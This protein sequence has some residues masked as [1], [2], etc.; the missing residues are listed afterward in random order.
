MSW[1]GLANRLKSPISAK[2]VMAEIWATPRNA[3]MAAATLVSDHDG[4]NSCICLASRSAARLRFLDG[5]QEFF[6]GDL[7][8]RMLGS[9]RREPKPIFARPMPAVGINA[10]VPQ[11]ETQH[12]LLRASQRRHRR[13]PGVTK[14]AHRLMSVVRDP[15]WRQL[16]RTEQRGLRNGVAAVGFHPI[17]RPRRN[18]RG[19]DHLA[20]MAKR[21]EPPVK[22]VAARP[23]FTAKRQSVMLGE[24]PRRRRTQAFTELVSHYL[25]ADRFG[26]PGTGNDKGN[27]EGREKFTRLNYLTPVPWEPSL[28]ALSAKLVDKCR[29]RQNERAGPHEQ[30]IG[31]RLVT[32]KGAFR[33]FPA[34]PFD[35]CHKLAC[36]DHGVRR[37]L[38][39]R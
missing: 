36:Q 7:P 23:R 32:D 37:R 2:S 27:V 28:E 17:T 22:P 33:A 16:S 25:F 15:D 38:H 12:L 39:S 3:G 9:L 13:L 31:E 21:G 14:I 11:Q 5:L 20:V 18:E 4:A 26:R 8:R 29:T 35:A 10:P 19:R 6:E 30:T 34:T 1:R 24:D